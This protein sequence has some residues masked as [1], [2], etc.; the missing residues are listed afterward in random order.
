[1]RTSAEAIIRCQDLVKLYQQGEKTIYAVNNCNISIGQGTFTAI[2][3]KS[4]SGKSTLLSLMAG[5]TSPTKGSV[6]I[7]NKEIGRMNDKEISAFRSREM[8]FI[9]QSYCL[10]PVLTAKE[11]I[12]FPLK[13]MEHFSNSYFSE[14]C[15]KLD[16]ADR[17]DHLP[18]E[19][20]GGQQQRVAIARALIHRPNIVFADEPTGN[21]DKASAEAFILYL[22]KIQKDYRLTVVVVTHD[23]DIAARAN[24][25]YEIENGV[26]RKIR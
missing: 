21:L 11:N 12:L 5:F 16:I 6:F 23:M 4:G 7:N 25:V 13:N 8:G 17:L 14:L 9:F 26:A 3:G 18:S 24:C 19:L 20:S 10:F 15:D 22:E 1:M 2:T